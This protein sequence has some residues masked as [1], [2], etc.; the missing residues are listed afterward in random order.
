MAQKAKATS[1]PTRIV[2]L[3]GYFILYIMWLQAIALVAISVLQYAVF[4]H[5]GT[6]EVSEQPNGAIGSTMA[7]Y[8]VP[9]HDIKPAPEPSWTVD[10]GLWV[11]LVLVGALAIIYIGKTGA[12]LM[13]VVLHLLKVKITI[14]SLFAAKFIAIGFAF[15]LVAGS[16]LLLP[17]VKYIMPLNIVLATACYLLFAAQFFAVRRRK[18]AIKDIL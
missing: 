10:A 2:A 12:G 9:L 14:E 16:T 11:L 8:L 13:R 18:I 6:T 7:S 1:F 5:I 3:V 15:M 17:A 4:N